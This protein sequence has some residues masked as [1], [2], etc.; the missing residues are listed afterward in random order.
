MNILLDTHALL[1][2]I[3]GN[4]RLTVKHRE[5]ISDPQHRKFFS[6]VSFWEMAI[7][8]SSGKLKLERS[9]S[10][11]LPTEINVL[12][13]SLAHIERVQQLPFHHRDPFDRAIIAQALTEDMALLS[14]DRSFAAYGVQ[15]V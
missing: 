4:T 10:T 12:T 2:Y 11:L 7:K 13:L 15:L 3:A 6:I 1:W 8:S 5:L 14:V 9:L